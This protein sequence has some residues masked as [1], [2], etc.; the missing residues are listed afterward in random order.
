MF[1]TRNH[2]LFR[3]LS[4]ML[5]MIHMAFNSATDHQGGAA[6]E[7]EAAGKSNSAAFMLGTLGEQLPGVSDDA[8][9]QADD[10][11]QE[12]VLKAPFL[13]RA[14]V[15]KATRKAEASS[16]AFASAWRQIAAAAGV[17]LADGDVENAAQHF[18]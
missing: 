15:E 13:P 10:K 12:S 3:Q 8:A 16:A 6:A 9:P 14:D 11:P 1:R 5:G 7:A 18:I 4:P 2:R 17:E